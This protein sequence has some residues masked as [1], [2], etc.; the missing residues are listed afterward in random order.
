M[1]SKIVLDAN[2]KRMVAYVHSGF[3]CL[4]IAWNVYKVIDDIWSTKK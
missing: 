3:T 2:A 4:V 1:F